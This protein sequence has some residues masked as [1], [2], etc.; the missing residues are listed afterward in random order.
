MS[1]HPNRPRNDAGRVRRVAVALVVVLVVGAGL[2]VAG[3]ASPSG[4]STAKKS[5][6][7]T[8]PFTTPSGV[9]LA[10]TPPPWRLPV[11]AKPYIAAAGLSVLSAEQLEVHYHAHLD[12]IADNKKVTVPA[13]IGFVVENG[14]ATGITVLHTHDTSGIVHIESATD[15]VFTLGQ[16]FTEWGVALNTNQVGGLEVDDT[17]VLQAYVNGRRLKGD[18]ATIRLKPHLEI[19]LWYGPAGTKAKVPKSYRF[20]EGL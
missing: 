18:P 3:A 12:I 16:L 5:G 20:P 6:V 15:D 9:A 7:A 13:G 2:L 19:A 10:E 8:A 11:D 17:H 14:R 1:P 4:A